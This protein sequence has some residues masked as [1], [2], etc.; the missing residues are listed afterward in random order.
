VNSTQVVANWLVGREIV[1]EEQQGRRKAGYGRELLLRLADR[2]Q[3]RFG[4][5]YSLTN[6]KLFRQFYLTY[7]RLLAGEIGH[8]LR[9]PFRS[10]S[11]GVPGLAL[12]A[13]IGHTPCDESWEPGRFHPGIAWSLY[14]HLLKV[15]ST[16]A[17]DFYEIEAVRNRWAAREL[18]R[19]INSL[20]FQRL[21]KSRDKTGL[22]R[23][24]R[25]GQQIATAADVFKD[26]V[27]IEFLGLPESPRLVES[28]LEHALL[29][30]LQ[31]FLLELGRGFAF[32]ARQ[33][34]LTLDGDHFYVD[35]VFYHTV[36]KCHVLID[37]KVGRLTHADLGQMQL[38][39]NYYDTE[40]RTSGDNPTLGLILCTD[41]NDAVVK[42]LLGPDQSRK[43][44]ASR[45]QL[46]LPTEAELAGELIRK[47]ASLGP[48]GRSR[49]R[50]PTP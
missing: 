9:D 35:L 28:D 30:N 7:P 47:L 32:V 45:Y 12:P 20:L 26:P 42:Y 17:R 6:L 22:L 10:S 33:Q 40:R 24:A 43:I 49:R 16:E 3:R 48:A 4:G 13:A 5:G 21:A 50:S 8:T 15:E 23:L 41:K 1:E 19:Q 46:H 44:F 31:S 38:Y 14:R 18:E 2:L 25:E 37:L 34:R 27:I 29:S 36:L 39:V 11:A